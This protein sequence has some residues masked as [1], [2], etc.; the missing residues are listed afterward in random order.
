MTEVRDQRSAVRNQRPEINR[1]GAGYAGLFLC[2]F[3]ASLVKSISDL[4]LLISVLC[5]M[6]L[7]L[8]LPAQAQ[9]PKKIPVIGRLGASSAGGEAARIEAFRHGLQELGYIEGKNIVIEWRH[10]EGKFDRLPALAA[11]LVRLK[12]EVIVTG[13]GNATRAVK[14]ATSTIPIVMA[15]LGDPVVD[16]FVT[17]LARPGGNITGL[18]R[19]SRS[20]TAKS[21][22]C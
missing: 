20:W 11:E 6:L 3:C 13:G 22:S 4:R 18:S 14:E 16:G 8:C 5:A 21:W 7:A 17:S 15:Q 10:A 2:A 1:R 19:L 12:V 9:Q